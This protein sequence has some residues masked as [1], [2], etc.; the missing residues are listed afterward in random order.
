MA[1]CKPTTGKQVRLQEDRPKQQRELSPGSEAPPPRKSSVRKDQRRPTRAEIEPPVE[2]RK[3]ARKPDP[4]ENLSDITWLVDDEPLAEQQVVDSTAAPKKVG[5]KQL[6]GSSPPSKGTRRPSSAAGH[7]G[8]QSRQGQQETPP[9]QP[10]VVAGSEQ[11]PSERSDADPAAN[12]PKLTAKAASKHPK[13]APELEAVRPVVQPQEQI[14]DEG[15]GL[16]AKICDILTQAGK[17]GRLHDTLAQA[18]Q[19]KKR[20]R[21]PLPGDSDYD[22]D[23]GRMRAE[24][25]AAAEL[26]TFAPPGPILVD[27][28][29]CLDEEDFRN[30]CKE[31]D[32]INAQSRALRALR[33]GEPEVPDPDGRK[34]T[35]ALQ[36]GPAKQLLRRDDGDM[37]TEVQSAG[38]TW[39]KL[40]RR[41]SNAATAR[42]AP[43]GRPLAK[44]V[45]PRDD[46]D[47]DTEVQSAGG[48]WSKVKDRKGNAVTAQHAPGDWQQQQPTQQLAAHKAKQL[49]PPD[50][51]D[52]DTEVQS[53]GGKWSK[54]KD[55]R[56]NAGMAQ[57][58]PTDRPRAEKTLEL[59]MDDAEQVAGVVWR[60]PKTGG[61][62]VKGF[63]EG[64]RLPEG[65]VV[66]VGD[67]LVAIAEQS[68]R[69]LP[70]QAIREIWRAVQENEKETLLRLTL[71]EGP[72]P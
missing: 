4:G 38:G 17:S 9:R 13:D 28:R 43:G 25:N 71:E 60:F 8:H 22:S 64:A 33:R 23:Y 54:L 45:L 68:V 40:K 1:P 18:G 48:K 24:D 36:D 2:Q 7:R 66:L 57:H 58:A 52:M 21:G 51:G 47:N 39:G 59:D 42:H 65:H 26:I 34:S 6:N 70:E 50:D 63:R 10:T 15:V 12:K 30:R 41:V 14:S 56:G 35:P 55:R 44:D 49:L 11:L 20:E 53:V 31:A 19:D 46:G 67:E 5:V 3:L 61:A 29:D 32:R 16:Q 27:P 62:F 37:D 72:V 69:G